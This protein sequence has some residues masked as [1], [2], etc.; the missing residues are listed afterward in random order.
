MAKHFNN[1]D[2]IVINDENDSPII[3]QFSDILHDL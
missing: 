1:H 3:L 2:K